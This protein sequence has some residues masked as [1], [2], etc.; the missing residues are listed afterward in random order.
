VAVVGACSS[1]CGAEEA[2]Y[3]AVW[4]DKDDFNEVLISPTMIN[5]HWPD[6]VLDA[7]EKVRSCR[8]ILH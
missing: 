3:E 6:N 4:A 5:D 1:W 2:T 8:R 7:L